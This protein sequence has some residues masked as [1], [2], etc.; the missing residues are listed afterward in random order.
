MLERNARLNSGKPSRGRG[1]PPGNP[2][3][4][5]DCV[6]ALGEQVIAG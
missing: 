2:S 1:L 3:S 5:V 6:L 4:L